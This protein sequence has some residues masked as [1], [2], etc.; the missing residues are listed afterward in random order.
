MLRFAIECVRRELK[1]QKT[2][3]NIF[4]VSLSK[5]KEYETSF[6]RIFRGLLAEDLKTILEAQDK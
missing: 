2:Y 4:E 1:Q 6:K 5:Q 3:M